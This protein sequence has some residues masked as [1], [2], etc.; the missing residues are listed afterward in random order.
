[1]TPGARRCG[2]IAGVLGAALLTLLNIPAIGAQTD[3]VD[4]ARQRV[5][6]TS[7]P[8]RKNWLA[9]WRTPGSPRCT[10]K[11]GWLSPRKP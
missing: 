3:E 9:L 8:S 1:M 6:Q 4:T 7:R 10:P 5:A 11:M 2:L